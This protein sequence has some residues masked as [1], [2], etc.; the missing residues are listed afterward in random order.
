MDKTIIQN[1]KNQGD[2]L[3]G[4]DL[5]AVGYVLPWQGNS[6]PIGWQLTAHSEAFL[7]GQQT[8]YTS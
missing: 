1:D 3:N 6:V 8:L 4:S 5:L 2:K 7:S